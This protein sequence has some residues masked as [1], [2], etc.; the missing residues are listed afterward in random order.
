MCEGVILITVTELIPYADN[1]Q[2]L[3]V[4]HC[5]VFLWIAWIESRVDNKAPTALMWA[6]RVGVMC[7]ARFFFRAQTLFRF[8]WKQIIRTLYIITRS[9]TWILNSEEHEWVLF[10]GTK[11][12][13]NQ[14]LGYWSNGCWVEMFLFRGVRKKP[15][16]TRFGLFVEKKFNRK[17]ERVGLMK[18]RGRG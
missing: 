10:R 13:L 8:V 18:H 6:Q 4:L 3:N 7:D 15:T 1:M 5:F 17:Q 11:S 9:S 14:S 12:K 16:L 2:Q